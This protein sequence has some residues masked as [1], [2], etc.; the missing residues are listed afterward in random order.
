MRAISYVLS[1]IVAC[2]FRERSNSQEWKSALLWSWSLFHVRQF[3]CMQ[4]TV[5]MSC[6]GSCIH[7]STKD[8]DLK[9]GV[10][11]NTNTWP[12][13]LLLF[14]LLCVYV[15]YIHYELIA[16]SMSMTDII[17]TT[18]KSASPGRLYVTWTLTL[19]VEPADWQKHR[20]WSVKRW[21]DKKPVGPAIY[22]VSKSRSCET[23]CHRAYLLVVE[24]IQ[25][26]ICFLCQATVTL[27][28]GQGHTKEHPHE[29]HAWDSIVMPILNGRLVGR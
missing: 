2:N 16:L 15:F 9:V 29:C 22:I 18:V 8:S 4:S 27:H 25:R 14:L 21:P 28:Q 1:G 26:W 5:R 7:L 6:M 3:P 11:K 24:I 23:E 10:R 13:A 19:P 12:L 20:S 17:I